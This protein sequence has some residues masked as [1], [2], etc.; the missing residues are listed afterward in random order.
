[1]RIEN[2]LFTEE[3]QEFLKYQPRPF[4][5]IKP[6]GSHYL[7]EITQ[8]LEENRIQ[9][10]EVF[11]IKDWEAAARAIYEPQLKASSQDFNVGFETHIWL[12]KYLFGNC[13]LL[14]LVNLPNQKDDLKSKS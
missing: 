14:L 9:I 10:T 8:T 2:S 1:M 11:F 5:I 6:D 7:P 13:A 3:K 12:T 4:I